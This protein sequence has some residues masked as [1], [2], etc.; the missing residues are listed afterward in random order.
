MKE[1][2]GGEWF[3]ALATCWLLSQFHGQIS[4]QG[5]I[6]AAAKQGVVLAMETAGT[7]PFVCLPAKGGVLRGKAHLTAEKCAGFNLVRI[8]CGILWIL[9]EL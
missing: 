3:T 2:G 8:R 9:A 1:E 6:S 7:T 5:K 4:K